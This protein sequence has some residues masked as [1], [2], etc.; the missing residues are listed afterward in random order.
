M[1][2]W[3]FLTNHGR[4]LLFISHDPDARLRDLAVALDVTERTA[5]GI[6]ADLTEAGYVVKEKEG[7]RNRYHIQTHLPLRDSIIR[8]RTIGEVLDLLLGVKRRRKT[9]SRRA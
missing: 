5:Y 1:A 7:R 9:R 6:M 3:S 8:E 4:A 2:D